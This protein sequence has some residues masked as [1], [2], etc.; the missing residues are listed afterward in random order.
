MI[1]SIDFNKLNEE[2]VIAVLKE[3][4]VID[5]CYCCN[6]IFKSISNRSLSW[7]RSLVSKYKK[8]IDYIIIKTAIKSKHINKYRFFTHKGLSKYINETDVISKKPVCKYFG[9][10]MKKIKKDSLDS[11]IVKDSD[12]G[13]SIGFNIKIIKWLF[14]K[15]K[16]LK[17]FKDIKIIPA[18]VLKQFILD[19]EKTDIKKSRK[20]K[21]LKFLSEC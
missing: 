21:L 8:D 14:D 9:I 6:E 7:N 20:Q 1:K 12:I 18:D 5:K 11:F 16:R 3:I 2:K 4:T 19:Y 13:S 15:R 10:T 17:Q